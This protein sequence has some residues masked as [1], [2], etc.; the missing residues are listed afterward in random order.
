VAGFFCIAAAIAL[1]LFAN[2]ASAMNQQLVWRSGKFNAYRVLLPSSWRFRD[3]SSPS[4]H[5]TYLWYDPANPLHK[6]YVTVSGCVGCV[7]TN[8]DPHR[9]NPQGE[10]PQNTQHTHWLGPWKL[11]FSAFT[12]DN[13]YPENGLV[14]VLNRGGAVAGSEIVQLWL[15]ESQHALATQILNSFRAHG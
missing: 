13:P 9:P 2:S 15:P 11:A 5:A 12:T 4:D 3:A 1:G 6:L 14:I 8:L 10:L 7:E